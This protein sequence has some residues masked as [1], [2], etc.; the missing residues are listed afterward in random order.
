M[1]LLVLIGMLYQLLRAMEVSKTSTTPTESLQFFI[2]FAGSEVGGMETEDLLPTMETTANPFVLQELVDKAPKL[3]QPY[4]YFCLMTDERG[5]FC[6]SADYLQLA[7]SHL[8]LETNARLQRVVRLTLSEGLDLLF[9]ITNDLLLADDPLFNG[10]GLREKFCSRQSLLGSFILLPDLNLI[11][12]QLSRLG[13]RGSKEEGKPS[14]PFV[15]ILIP[16]YCK[17][18]TTVTEQ[19]LEHRQLSP[20]WNALLKLVQVNLYNSHLR[21]EVSTFLQTHILSKRKRPK[22]YG[23]ELCTRL[24][25]VAATISVKGDLLEGLMDL[26]GIQERER[27]RSLNTYRNRP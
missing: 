15:E 13:K 4:V 16:R 22:I 26:A 14:R 8:N 12:A 5:E 25:S 2:D 19:F 1:K 21:K 18:F 27:I 3:I 10:Q 23:V 7:F 6:P 9:A 20:F 11:F 24:V 17:W